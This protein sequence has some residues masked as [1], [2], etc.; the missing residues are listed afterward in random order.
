MST[1][2]RLRALH[3]ANQI[4][5]QRPRLRALKQQSRQDAAI[6]VAQLIREPPEWLASM[7]VE[8]LLHSLPRVGDRKVMVL[9]RQAAVDP[10][11]LVGRSGRVQR[12]VLSPRQRERLAGLLEE[13]GRGKPIRDRPGAAGNPD[14]L[15]CRL[16]GAPGRGPRDCSAPRRPFP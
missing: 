6:H 16:C 11:T 10:W 9:M 1:D 7:R 4:R 5:L 2:Q 12:S 3:A 15:R 13:Y 14:L 8:Q